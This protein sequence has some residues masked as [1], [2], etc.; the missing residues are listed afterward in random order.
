[1][2]LLIASDI[3]GS[4]LY[5][6]KLADIYRAAG[7]DRLILLGDLLYHG[8][9]NDLPEGYDPKGVFALLNS[10][11]DEILC[12]RG[13]CDADVDQMVLDFPITP[14]SMWLYLDGQPVFATHGHIWGRG[15]PP[16]IGRKDILLNGHT[17]LPA[18]EDTGR[19]I[20]LNPGSISLPKDGNKHSYM[21][22]ENRK[23]T[24]LSLD[25]EPICSYAF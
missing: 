18:A 7:A 15:N 17:H 2:K 11:K 16:L 20:Y 1:M 14:E 8:P 23:F 10:M 6:Q 24:V 13:N 4:L 25:G 22:Y 3:H 21:V 12:V 9:R 5:T 19:F